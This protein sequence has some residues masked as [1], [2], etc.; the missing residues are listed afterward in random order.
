MVNQEKINELKLLLEQKETNLTELGK[1]TL[2]RL[3]EELFMVK[4]EESAC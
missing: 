1:E 2:Q 4:D 3:K